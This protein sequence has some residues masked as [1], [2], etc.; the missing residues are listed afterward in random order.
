MTLISRYLL[1]FILLPQRKYIQYLELT[2][3]LCLSQTHSPT[4]SP[5]R[6]T[7]SLILIFGLNILNISYFPLFP[8]AGGER[9]IKGVSSWEV[10]RRVRG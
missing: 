1:L 8:P 5:K 7:F 4:L 6:Y 3:L 10:E 9:G 2:L